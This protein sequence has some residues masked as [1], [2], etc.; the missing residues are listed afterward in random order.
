MRKI[1]ASI[2]LLA[3][4]LLLTGCVGT[5]R[6]PT[7]KGT[8]MITL[9]AVLP[10]SVIE[11]TPRLELVLRQHTRE[12]R[13]PVPYEDGVA[14]IAVD[15][16]YEGVW[17][18]TLQLVDDEGDVIYV[19]QQDVSV[20]ADQTSTVEL[21]LVP[22]PG[23]LRVFIDL[24]HFRDSDA[25]R[26]ARLSVTPG[27]YSSG[28][29]QEGASTIQI[30]REL[31]PQTYDYR[32]SL[33]GEKDNEDHVV[34]HS[35][36]TPVTIQPGKVTTILWAA[37][38]GAVEVIGSIVPAPEPPTDFAV[39][40]VGDGTLRFTWQATFDAAGYRLYELRT[41]FDYYRQLAEIPAEADVWVVDV[42]SLKTPHT[43]QYVLTSFN[44]EGFE[45]P[46]T[47]PVSVQFPVPTAPA[48]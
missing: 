9:S 45:S 15:S 28:T 41:P 37:E 16:L 34:Y 26:R 10:A 36:W 48:P 40:V 38:T 39:E 20:F 8:G 46:R 23:L 31:D 35:P 44:S 27:G 2:M 30:E 25:V 13:L 11:S 14:A 43:R 5:F 19:A 6:V 12:Q 32:I 17:E 29:R 22:A 33:Y 4:L 7:P 24:E 47:L 3:S 18:V 42:S 21:V 1:R